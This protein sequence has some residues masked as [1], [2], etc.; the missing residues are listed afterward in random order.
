M[1]GNSE[2]TRLDE[3]IEPTP[4]TI[5]RG[6]RLVLLPDP[7]ARARLGRPLLG[8][9]L[10]LRTA[11][12][13]REAGFVELIAA[14]GLALAPPGAREISIGDVIGGPGLMLYEGTCIDPQ[15]LR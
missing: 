6:L 3:G 2:W 11:S 15:L 14:P 4:R 10:A 13:A 9:P 12:A 1:S 5:D 8:I 7:E